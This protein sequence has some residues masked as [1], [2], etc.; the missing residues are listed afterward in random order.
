[1]RVRRALNLAVDK[2][3]INRALF[4]GMAVPMTS[5]LPQAQW[6]FDQSLAGYGFDPDQA[7]K[8]LAEAGL[9]P[10]LKVELLTYNSPRGYN[11]AGADLAV[12]VQGYLKRVGVEAEVQRR[13]M[14][15]FLS[16]VRSGKYEGLRMGGWTGDNG[17]PDNFAGAL[18]ASKEIPINNT[19]H[20]HN[21][22]VDRLLAEAARTVDHEKR[23]SLYN[24]IQK[25]IVEDAPW[26]FINSVLQVRA[27]RKEVHGYQ[28]NPT[29]M[30][31]DMD[32]VSLGT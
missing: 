31:F 23:V 27:V 1:V 32:Q 13:D 12:A 9:Q 2:A 5:P 19:S 18:F 15:A 10:G 14:G 25:R 7:K 30:F 16:T 11:P 17:D 20:Y 29:Q 26:I 28:L 6:G 21:A 4:Q 8:L 3:A 22:E 24:D